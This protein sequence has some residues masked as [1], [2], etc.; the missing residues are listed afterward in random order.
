MI[1]FIGFAAAAIVAI[2][3]TLGISLYKNKREKVY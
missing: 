2:G 1:I 3:V